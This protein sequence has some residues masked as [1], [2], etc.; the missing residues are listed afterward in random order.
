MYP[1]E[2]IVE[3]VAVLVGIARHGCVHRASRAVVHN[4]RSAPVIK[5]SAQH[6][7]TAMEEA[8]FHGKRE[9]KAM[10]LVG[11]AR[12]ALG[13]RVI[14]VLDGCWLAGNKSILPIIDGAG[15]GARKPEIRTVRNAAIHR[16]R[17]SA[18]IAGSGALKFIDSAQ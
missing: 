11:D 15:I 13:T 5:E 16:Q 4:G 2:T 6:L 10:A 8:W 9:D 1:G 7:V 14:G 18:V 3:V 17:S 12:T